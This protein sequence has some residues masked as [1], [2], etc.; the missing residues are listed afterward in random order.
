MSTMTIE[1]KSKLATQLENRKPQRK[2][3]DVVVPGIEGGKIAFE[4][5][6][7]SG[8]TRALTSAFAMRDEDSTGRDK[9]GKRYPSHP[10]VADHKGHFD[11]LHTIAT[12][13]LASRDPDDVDRPAFPSARWMRDNLQNH[14]IEY[15]TNKYNRFVAENYPGGIDKLESTEKLV[16]FAHMVAANSK[17]DLPDSALADF[18]HEV[19]VECFIRLCK[20]WEEL[21]QEND[22]LRNENLSLRAAGVV[23]REEDPDGEDGSLSV[24]AVRLLAETAN[25]KQGDAVVN[26]APRIMTKQQAMVAMDMLGWTE[27]SPSWLRVIA[28]V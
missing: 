9:E 27:G 19:L 22:A 16:E 18:S 6:R 8:T 14:E 3:F 2:T 1:H 13:H 21:G 28:D 10:A 20:I 24:Y 4:I 7:H 11:N 15:L 25:S 17:N 12:L 5:L 26:A 23:P